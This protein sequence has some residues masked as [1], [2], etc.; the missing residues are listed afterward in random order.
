ML[1]DRQRRRF[2]SR[3]VLPEGGLPDATRLLPRVTFGRRL[4][5]DVGCTRM[6]APVR[7]RRVKPRLCRKEAN[8]E[9]FEMLLN[10][11]TAFSNPLWHS[12]NSPNLE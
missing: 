5:K 1:S 11:Q 8:E 3:T 7:Y 2:A 4:D 12:T 10:L 9:A 6:A